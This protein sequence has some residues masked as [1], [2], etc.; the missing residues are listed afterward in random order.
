MLGS[1]LLIECMAS[2]STVLPMVTDTREL[3]MRVEGKD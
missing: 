1:T 2:E 3:G